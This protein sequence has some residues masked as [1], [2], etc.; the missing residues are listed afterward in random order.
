MKGSIRET[1]TDKF[2]PRQPATVATVT[3]AVNSPVV[4]QLVA[5][6]AVVNREGLDFTIHP[7]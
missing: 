2:T 1:E 7:L 4:M 6:L 5:V 3:R